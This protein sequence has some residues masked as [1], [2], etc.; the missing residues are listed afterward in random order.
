M[1]REIYVACDYEKNKKNMCVVT[2]VAVSLRPGFH[3][4]KVNAERIKTL[5]RIRNAL[6]NINYRNKSDYY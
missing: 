3:H 1:R 5:R 4:V 6:L 2:R